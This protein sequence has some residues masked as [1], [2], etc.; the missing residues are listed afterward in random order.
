[1]AGQNSGDE[2]QIIDYKDAIPILISAVSEV[3][4]EED[5]EFEGDD[6]IGVRA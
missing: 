1:M 5:N 2:K 6:D 3:D 4:M